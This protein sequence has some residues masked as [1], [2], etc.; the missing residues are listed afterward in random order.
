MSRFP[1]VWPSEIEHLRTCGPDLPVLYFAPET[2]AATARR[3]GAGFP[4]LVTYAVKANPEPAVIG[5][6]WAAGMEAFDVASPA[7][8][9]LVRAIAPGATLHYNNPVRSPA[10]IAHAARAGVASWA[11]DG[12]SELAKLRGAIPPASEVAVRLALPVAGAAYDFGAKFG[13]GPDGAAVLLK[14]V[15]AAGFRPAMTF[16]PGTQCPAP[17]A[18]T[19]YIETCASVSRAAGIPLAR[20]NVGGGFPADRGAGAPELAAIFAAIRGA[21]QAFGPAPPPLVCEPGRAMVAEAFTLATRVKAIREDGALFLNDGLYGHLAEAALM[22]A[23]ERVRLLAPDGTPRRGPLEPRVLF[24]P[25]CDSVDRLPAPLMLPSDVAEGDY[26]LW[27]GL[28]AYSTATATR[29]NG[30]GACETVTVRRAE[31]RAALRPRLSG[32]ASA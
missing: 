12:L 11:I 24:G 31:T 26:L 4:G 14:A 15:A 5:T 28:G 32:A 10:E 25:T 20:L 29:F 21:V 23:V 16:H 8:I 19:R 6:L 2:L 18:W 30:Y 9:D 27:E 3:F 1:Q 13:E 17:A 7:E 22:G